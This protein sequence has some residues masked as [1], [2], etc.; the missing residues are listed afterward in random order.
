VSAPSQALAAWREWTTVVDVENDRID[1]GSYRLLPMVYT[2]L[3]RH[4]PD[5]PRLKMLQGLH[6]RTWYENQMRFR[7]CRAMFETFAGSGIDMLLLKGY[8]L[9]AQYYRDLGAR[10]MADIDVLV[11]RQRAMD[12]I[13]LLAAHGWIS[14]CFGARGVDDDMLD[15]KA[16]H[17][18]TDGRGGEIDLHW[19]VLQATLD[20]RVD[21][22]FRDGSVPLQ[23]R[24]LHF[25]TLNPGDLLLHVCTHGL[26]C[27]DV[28]P[29]RWVADA[30][31]IL[32]Q[33]PS[34]DWGR[35]VR[36]ASLSN[37]TLQAQAAFTYLRETFDADVP[38]WV[39]DELAR[40]P[41]STV[42]RRLHAVQ[43]SPGILGGVH[44]DWYRYHADVADRKPG[45]SAR[46]PLAFLRYLRVLQGKDGLW[47]VLTWG[48]SRLVYRLSSSV[49]DALRRR[50]P[51]PSGRFDSTQE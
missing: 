30:M 27:N 32:R 5:E 35:L 15:V 1:V 3:R 23:V 28:S 16:S 48:G 11:P 31:A 49:R 42:R 7:A 19:H 13:R 43:L 44:A 47:Q 51:F 36:I 50:L 17:G 45:Y 6:R 8:P 46:S 41:V 37:T 26:V 2:N 34:I 25:R 22:E 29:I 40:I 33:A 12:A 38:A 9:A 21:A 39:A 24:D 20:E 14:T 4:M 18:F 10:P